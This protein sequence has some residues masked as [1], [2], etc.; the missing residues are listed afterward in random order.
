MYLYILISMFSMYFWLVKKNGTFS[1]YGE[2]KNNFFKQKNKKKLK[3][4]FSCLM[5][6]FY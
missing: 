1:S 6:V 3:L 4:L 5:I 2:K